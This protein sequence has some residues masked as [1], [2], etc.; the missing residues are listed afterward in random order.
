MAAI[1]EAARTGPTI[2]AGRRVSRTGGA[3][4]ATVVA[5]AADG[6]NHDSGVGWTVVCQ[7]TRSRSTWSGAGEKAVLGSA[8]GVAPVAATPAEVGAGHRSAGCGRSPAGP[9]LDRAGCRRDPGSG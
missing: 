9:G 8:A 1:S 7:D 6:S 2:P 5:A 3:G 4:T